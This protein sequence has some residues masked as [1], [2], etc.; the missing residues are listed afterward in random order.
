ML[1]EF[2]FVIDKNMKNKLMETKLFKSMNSFSGV[3]HKILILLAPVIRR[4]HYWGKSRNN[5]YEYVKKS[6]D[7]GVVHIHAYIPEVVYR[8]LKLLH[9]DLNFYRDRKSVV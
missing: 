1:H 2:H 3:V 6:S 4:E 5:R 8:Q 7:G 9:H